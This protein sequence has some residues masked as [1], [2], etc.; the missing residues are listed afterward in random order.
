MA[1]MCAASK[2]SG[3]V[4]EVKVHP[5][6]CTLPCPALR[7]CP[8]GIGLEF[9]EYRSGFSS[10]NPHLPCASGVTMASVCA[11]ATSSM[12]TYPAPLGGAHR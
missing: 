1:S 4:S 11:A 3:D 12:S 7:W 9:K 8:G 5:A 10:P 6:R 2:S